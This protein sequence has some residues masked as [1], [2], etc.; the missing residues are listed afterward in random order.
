MN[1]PTMPGMTAMGMKMMI[2]ERVVASTARP[3]S[4]V[5]MKA[6]SMAVRFFSS[7]LRKMF[8][9]TTMASS[10]TMPT[11]RVSASIVI[12]FRLKPIQLSREKVEMIEV[13]MAMAAMRVDRQLR[14]KKST[15]MAAKKPPR[16]R[17]SSTAL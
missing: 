11:T 5:P 12:W 4:F 9:S 17:C 7:M 2:S 14:M 16:I 1:R 13:G 6:A 15:M 8:S 10:M 3:I